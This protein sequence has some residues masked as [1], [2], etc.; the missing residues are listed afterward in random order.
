MNV[1]IS[2]PWLHNY[3]AMTFF[4][5]AGIIM[6]TIDIFFDLGKNK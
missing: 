4:L 1:F 6:E 3:V 5:L 2:F